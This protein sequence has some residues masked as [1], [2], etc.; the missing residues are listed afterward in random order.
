MVFKRACGV[1]L[2]PTSLPGPYGIGDLGDAAFRFIDFLHHAGQTYW[3]VLPLGHTGFGDSPYQLFSAFAGNPLLISLDQLAA[4]GWLHRHELDHGTEADP[5]Q[6]DFG[7]VIPAKLR[8]LE[9]AARRFRAGMDSHHRDAYHQFWLQ[10][11]WWLDDYA[12]FVALKSHHDGANWNRW[13]QG[14]VRREPAALDRWRKDLHEEIESI[15]I[16]QYFFTRQWTR[17]RRHANEFGVRIVGDIP[18]YVAHDS[19]DVWANQHI[20]QLDETGS[21]AVMSGVPPDYFSKTGQLWG[22]PIYRW[23]REREGGYSWWT[24]RFRETFRQ[25]DIVRLDHFRG[26]EAYWQVPAGS[27]TAIRGEWVEG[28]GA[29]FFDHLR[30]VFG[31]DLPIIAENLGVITEPVENLRRRFNLPGMA[32]LQFAFRYDADCVDLPHNYTRDT[33]AYTGTHDNDTTV[34]WWNS[35]GQSDSTRTEEAVAREKAYA[36]KYLDTDGTQ[37]HWDF[38][39]T[40]MASVADTVIVPAQDLLGLGGEARMNLPGRPSGNWQWRLREGALTDEIGGRL[41]ELAKLY[42]RYR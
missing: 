27:D 4:E 12:L 38:I 41:L 34:G 9:T 35:T 10:H 14:L 1:L 29:A 30:T 24:A 25:V 28:P 37:I 19:V 26:F 17:V 36:R 5:D 22:N 39:R 16:W 42:G 23:D 33:V 7:A 21:P 6:V 31:H 32:I 8:L 15:K 11:N 2:H 20:F 40:L 3:Q 13:P 18:I